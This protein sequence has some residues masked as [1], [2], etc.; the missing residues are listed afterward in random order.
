V[1]YVLIKAAGLPKILVAPNAFVQIPVTIT[2]Q[3][4]SQ[5]VTELDP[6]VFTVG[7]GGNPQPTYQWFQHGLAI[8][9]ATNAVYTISAT[10]LSYDGTKFYVVAANVTS[11]LT[12]SVTSSV[13]T[14]TVSPDITPPAL[15]GARSASLSQI[16]ATFSEQI[17]PNTAT[18]PLNYLVAGPGGP[19]AISQASLDPS[20]TSVV[21]TV[22]PMTEGSRYTLTV[23]NL[24][25]L[26]AAGNTI[27]PNSQASFIAGTFV[28][29]DIGSPASAGSWE[30]VQGGYNATGGGADIGGATDQFFFSYRPASAGREPWA[31]RRMGEGWVDGAIDA[32]PRELICSGAGDT[33]P[34]R[35]FL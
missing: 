13:A 30:P 9:G 24:T 27:N 22:S 23:N 3:P 21:L 28:Q 32:R 12:H 18:N 5:T 11:N 14:L 10:P 20:Q 25:D 35:L 1:D 19:L 6:A 26:S 16:L 2:N 7:A 8:P 15:L 33:H 29:V 31:V 17:S 4:Q 34:G